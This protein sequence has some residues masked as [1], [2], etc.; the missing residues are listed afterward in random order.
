MISF[1]DQLA[2]KVKGKPLNCH[3]EGSGRWDGAGRGDGDD[4]GALRLVIS[5]S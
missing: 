2:I 5:V 1:Y 4:T 3:S